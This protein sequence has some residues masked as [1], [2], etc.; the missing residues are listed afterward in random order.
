M[1]AKAIPFFLKTVSLSLKVKNVGAV[2]SNF[3]VCLFDGLADYFFLGWIG[4]LCLMISCVKPNSHIKSL[5][6]NLEPF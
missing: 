4:R 2:E 6:K 1:E 3:S 5:K